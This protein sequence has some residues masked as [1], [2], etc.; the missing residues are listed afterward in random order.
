MVTT[1]ISFPDRVREILERNFSNADINL[2]RSSGT[3]RLS[4]YIIW[5]GFN[6]VEQ[7]DR[8][9]LIYNTLRDELQ[10]DAAKISIILAYSPEEW[11]AM[12][13]E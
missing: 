8:Q 7:L 4:G 11:E 3:E 12:H 5:S 6:K 1:V 13:E 9:R 10:A 2:D